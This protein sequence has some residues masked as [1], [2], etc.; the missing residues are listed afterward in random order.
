[1]KNVAKN[2]LLPVALS[3]ACFGVAIILFYKFPSQPAIASSVETGSRQTIPA[4]A[5]T[6]IGK[7]ESRRSYRLTIDSPDDRLYLQ[8]PA[9][10]VPKFGYVRN[11]EAVWCN[12]F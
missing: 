9:N 10:Y 11:V 4:P 7:I 1:M 3:V 8:C 6:L 5:V 12:R 2:I